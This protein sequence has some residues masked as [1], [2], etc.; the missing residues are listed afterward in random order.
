M[1]EALQESY[2]V[3]S[4][5]RSPHSSNE[6]SPSVSSSLNQHPS[7]LD[8]TISHIP[9]HLN[10]SQ[11]PLDA[12][13]SSSNQ[14]FFDLNLFP[15][16]TVFPDFFVADDPAMVRLRPI[17]FPSLSFTLQPSLLRPRSRSSR[18]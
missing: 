12:A 5:V 11:L 13:S 3:A 4:A 15:E 2:R 10:A 6:P 9:S 17:S 14:A 18:R 7:P 8:P 1:A 16:S